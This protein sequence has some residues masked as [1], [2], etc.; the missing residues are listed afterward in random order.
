MEKSAE[1]LVKETYPD[2]SY[3]YLLNGEE[4]PFIIRPISSWTDEYIGAG[5]TLKGAWESALQHLLTIKN[6]KK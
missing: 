5:E 2:A 4:K 1:E 3:I 6:D